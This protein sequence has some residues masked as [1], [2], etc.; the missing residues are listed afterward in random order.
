MSAEH[1]VAESIHRDL[2][3]AHVQRLLTNGAMIEIPLSSA[4]RKVLCKR[5][6][7]AL[8][9]LDEVG[10]RFVAALRAQQGFARGAAATD[11]HILFNGY[12]VERWMLK[13]L[14]TLAHGERASRARPS[15]RWHVPR[16]W[17]N[18][19]FEG[20]PFPTGAG[21]YSPRTVRGR[22]AD[23]IVV[24]KIVG[25]SYGATPERIPLISGATE[26]TVV[27]VSMTIY[28]LDL[29]LRMSRP[30]EDGGYYRVRMWRKRSAAGGVSHIHLGWDEHPPTFA[31]H[32]HPVDQ[33]P[34]DDLPLCQRA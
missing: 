10:R 8:S 27:G 15:R 1:A 33:T 9:P 22:G 24:A 19:L 31:G 23:G 25:R 7:S 5:H 12:D 4:G 14:C 18:I 3:S 13:V 28:G 34:R 32:V 6:N 21:I 11:I 20:G 16:S 17:L 30:V 29:D 2:G 26:P